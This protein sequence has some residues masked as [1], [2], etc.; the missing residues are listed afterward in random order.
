MGRFRVFPN[1]Y[2]ML[3]GN[4]GTRKN[5]AINSVKYLLRDAGYRAFSA[6]KTRKEKFLQDLETGMM[7]DI[8]EVKHR[9]G[10]DVVMKNLFGADDVDDTTGQEPKE[11]MIVAP[12]FNTF[13]PAGDLEFLGD[14]G[15]LWDWDDE[16]TFF[17]YRLRNAKSV[18]IF[19]PTISILSGNTHDGFQQMFPTQAMGQGIIP[20]FILVHG[21]PSGKKFTFPSAGD[22][23][24]RAEI[25]RCFA[26]IKEKVTGTIVIREDARKALDIIYRSWHDLE[27]QRFKHYSTRRFTHLLKLC[28]IC[29][30]ARVSRV[31]EMQDIL[32]ANS[33]LTFTETAMP[34]ALGEFGKSRNSEA[35]NKIMSALYETRKPLKLPELWKMVSQDLEKIADLSNLLVNLQNADKI[36]VVKGEGFLPKQKPLDRKLVYVDYNLLKEFS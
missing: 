22:P 6:S 35:A 34:K 8:G 21:E 31:L 23:K 1:Q 27:D 26:Q 28:I 25:L 11:V 5:T 32:L 20:R 33:L 15:E 2:V 29:G 3:I 4:P 19:Q 24:L 36:Q 18:H 17:K 16:K 14:L 9:T 7:D 10:A 13:L 12:E 30:A